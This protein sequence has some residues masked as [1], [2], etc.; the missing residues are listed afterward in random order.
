MSD[1]EERLRAAGFELPRPSKP[2]GVY[3][4]AVVTGNLRNSR[5]VSTSSSTSFTSGSSSSSSAATAA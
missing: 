5:E 3:V 2:V 1:P 4:S